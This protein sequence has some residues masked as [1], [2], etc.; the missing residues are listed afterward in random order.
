MS[1]QCT[2]CGGEKIDY[3]KHRQERQATGLSQAAFARLMGISPQYLC[4]IEK[5]TRD[6]NVHTIQRF[7]DALAGL[8]KV[9][10]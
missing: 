4:E 6:W 9:I 7:R 10:R 8:E 5:G 2:H 3:L 1:Q